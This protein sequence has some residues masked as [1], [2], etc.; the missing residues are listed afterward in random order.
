MRTSKTSGGRSITRAAVML[1]S[2]WTLGRTRRFVGSS[3]AACCCVPNVVQQINH[4]GYKRH[5]LQRNPP[6]FDP[7][8]DIVENDDEYE[9]E[10][11]LEAVEEN[12]YAG[13]QIER[14]SCHCTRNTPVLNEV[15]ICS[16]H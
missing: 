8:G 6:R 3:C 16:R 7:D 11:D 10:D 13:I 4:A 1:T 12:P 9:D 5:I 14:Q 15:Q 2:C